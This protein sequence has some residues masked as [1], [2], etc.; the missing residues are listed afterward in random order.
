MRY[1][2]RTYPVLSK[3]GSLIGIVSVQD[4]E[5]IRQEEWEKELINSVMINKV[6]TA[7][8]S[9]TIQDAIGR[10]NRHDL[11]FLPVVSDLDPQKVVGGLSRTDIFQG[12]WASR[13]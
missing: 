7:R 5:T 6:I 10:M 8:E 12:E 13:L 9:D 3:N 1:F 11:D 2:H 4:V